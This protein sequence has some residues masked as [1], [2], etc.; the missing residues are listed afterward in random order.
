MAQ[1][2][3]LDSMAMKCDE[4]CYGIRSKN[5]ASIMLPSW[6]FAVQPYGVCSDCGTMFNRTAS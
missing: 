6:A 5:S 4:R 3:A 2:G 1:S